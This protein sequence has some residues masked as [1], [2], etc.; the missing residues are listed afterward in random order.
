MKRIIKKWGIWGAGLMLW[1]CTPN[2]A[3]ESKRPSTDENASVSPSG[4]KN[5]A[6]EVGDKASPKADQA[7]TTKKLL[8]KTSR[9]ITDDVTCE[10][11]SAHG[12]TDDWAEGNFRLGMRLLSLLP[13]NAAFSPWSVEQAIERILM[14]TCGSLYTEICQA[15]QMPVVSN[16]VTLGQKM[17]R[18]LQDQ[19]QESPLKTMHQLWVANHIDLRSQFIEQFKQLFGQPVYRASFRDEAQTVLQRINHEAAQITQGHVS[20]LLGPIEPETSLLLIDALHFSAPWAEDVQFFES[21]ERPFETPK[22]P[23]LASMMHLLGPVQQLE[24]EETTLI[25]LPMAHDYA[26][27]LVLPKLKKGEDD[28]SVL[29]RAGRVI[30]RQTLGE[31]KNAQ[32]VNLDLW[33]P[34]LRAASSLSLMPPL[35]RLGM[36]TV[37]GNRLLDQPLNFQAMTGELKETDSAEAKNVQLLD[38]MQKFEI[39]F[40]EWGAGGPAQHSP[41]MNQKAQKRDLKNAQ[42]LS[43]DHPF[44]Y[45]LWSEKLQTAILVGRMIKP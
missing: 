36:N 32:K 21:E 29:R 27:I 43:I 6:S 35:R 25:R 41:A 39:T 8:P 23:A 40:D 3:S 5:Q 20:E 17:E 7:L 10:R 34:K 24:I 2:P 4:A 44:F 38:L 19:A 31:L 33:M 42:S 12:S 15:M 16:L 22:G 14:G 30:S 13:G 11:P 18:M 26:F 37:F 28:E 1:A 9:V 45:C